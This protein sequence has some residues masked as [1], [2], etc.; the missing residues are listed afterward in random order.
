MKILVIGSGGREHALVWKIAQ[1]KRV[2]KI[3]CAPGNPGTAQYAQNIP[4]PVSEF[5]QLSAFALKNSVDMTVVG[6]ENPLIDGIADIFIKKNLKIIGPTKKAAQIEGSKVFAKQLMKKYKIPT[7]YFEVFDNYALASQYIRRRQ[8]P[9]VI[10]A[11]GPCLGK[12]VAVCTTPFDAQQ[13]LRQL[14]MENI[15]GDSGKKVVIEECLEGQE[16]SFMVATDGK[17][18]VSMLPSQDHKRIGDDDTGPNTGGMGAYTPV[19]IVKRKL[20]T[21]IE[22]NLIAPTIR[23]LAK[24]GVLYKGFLYPGIILT[25]K[26]PMVLEFNCRLGDPE[27]QILMFQLKSDIVDIFDAIDNNKIGKEK[28]QWFN[29]SSVC[30]VIA[31]AGYPG[32]YKK[33]NE[34]FGLKKIS[35]K[36]DIIA[37]HSATKLQGE[38]VVSYGGRVLGICAR[39]LNLKGAIKK[40]Y[41]AIGRKGIYFDGMQYRKDIGKKGLKN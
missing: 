5:G 11:D 17:N 32:E 28:F 38:N 41:K 33:G 16:V 14:M 10:K 18:F 29:G 6:P 12:G 22:K 25:R 27:T 39:D 1:S 34:I 20:F 35:H 37:F 30:V 15:F 19:P 7:A 4:I 40:A 26:G 31:T 21:Q 2:T 8:F 13:F 23:A 36:K 24:E 3:Y 9:L